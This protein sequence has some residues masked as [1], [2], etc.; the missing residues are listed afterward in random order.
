[1]KRSGHFCRLRA[2][3]VV[4][5]HRMLDVCQRHISKSYDKGEDEFVMHFDLTGLSVV[6]T[7]FGSGVALSP[8]SCRSI[9]TLRADLL[10]QNDA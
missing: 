6:A 1:M 4:D 7:Q 8:I 2:V 9:L 5:R 3:A 10:L